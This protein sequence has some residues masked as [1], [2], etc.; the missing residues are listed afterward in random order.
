MRARTEWVVPEK[1][2]GDV[3]VIAYDT[4]NDAAE[5]YDLFLI[6]AG[7][8][9]IVPD[10]HGWFAL[11]AET[12]EGLYGSWSK[13]V[14]RDATLNDVAV[15][16]GAISRTDAWPDSYRTMLDH[17]IGF[18]PGVP[19]ERR[20][21]DAQTFIDQMNRLADFLTSAQVFT[22]RTMPFD[23]LLAYQP[24]ID[25]TSH[26]RWNDPVVIRAA[27]VAADRAAGA[28]RS[29]A[30]VGGATLIVTGDHGLA[31]VDT[32]IHMNRIVAGSGFR[33]FASGNVAHLYGSGDADAVIA[34]LQAT[35]LFEQI[36]KKTPKS[37]RNSGDVVAYSLPRVLLSPSSDA[38]P[39]ARPDSTANHGAL[40]V[41][42]ELHT[43]LFATGTGTPRGTLGEI[44][45]TRIARF[46]SQLLGIQPPSAS[47]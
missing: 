22:I 32:E 7:D 13:F 41:H 35:G 16:W 38:P 26:T 27:F 2:R 21:L 34:M 4:T 9:E 31:P 11:S 18:W 8:R 20:E 37:H 46:V 15:Y 14:T 42:R 43:V 10:A 17:E 12:S 44:S 30:E 24:E 1:A 28:I 33:A 3:D 29:A 39:I 5:N 23:L 36:T 47:E 40:N 25:T 45:Q 19:D 6:E